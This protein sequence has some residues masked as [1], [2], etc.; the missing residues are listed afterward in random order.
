MAQ[1]HDKIDTS[2]ITYSVQQKTQICA[3]FLLSETDGERDA[4]ACVTLS[5]I[6]Y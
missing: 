4:V 1:Q 3:S 5:Y 6:V 2:D